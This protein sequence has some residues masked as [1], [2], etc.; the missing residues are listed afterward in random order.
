[1]TIDF[2]PLASEVFVTAD[3]SKIVKIFDLESGQEKFAFPDVHKAVISNVSWNNDGSLCATSAKDKKMRIFDPRSNQCVAEA[4]D[5]PGTKGSRVIWLGK[6]DLLFSVGFGKGSERQYSLSDPRNMSAKMI[7]NVIDN[8]S[9]TLLPFYDNDLGIM[10][11]AGKGD[12]NMRYYEITE[13][14]SPY[15]HFLNEF[16]SK[17]PQAGL[18]ALPKQMCDVKKCEV[19]KFL[20]ITPQG[21]VVPLRFEV[22]RIENVYFQEDLYPETWDLQPSM[23]STAWFGGEKKPGN[24]VS[25]NPD[26][27]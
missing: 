11:L 17:E 6:K 21:T 10:Y 12:G 2:H 20:K 9:S 4:D 23:S 3:A 5:H 13:S 14:E 8:S 7:V 24:L 22:P 16:K 25:L 19:M 18:T 27:K 26:K 1:L 15:V